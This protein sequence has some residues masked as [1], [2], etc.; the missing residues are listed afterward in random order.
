MSTNNAQLSSGK[1]DQLISSKAIGVIADID[2]SYLTDDDRIFLSQPEVCG[3]ILFSRNF[4]SLNQLQQLTAD[5]KSLRP[6]LLISADQEGGRVQRFRGGF[7]RIPAMMTFEKIWLTEGD[8][9][10]ASVSDM[11][12]LLALECR[13]AGVDLTYAPVLDIEQDCSQVIGDRAF[14]HTADGVT[15]LASAWCRGLARVGF[16]AIGKHFPGHGGVVADSHHELPIDPR[17]MVELQEDM[18]PFKCL[19][20]QG[21][22]AGIMPAHVIY[23]GVDKNH[24]AGFSDYWLQTVLRQE[25]Q[26]DG[27]I[28]SDDLSMTGAASAGDYSK[29]A[30]AAINA[31]ANALLACNDRHAAQVVIDTVKNHAFNKPRLDLSSWCQH[32]LTQDQTQTL[33]QRVIELSED[34]M[35]LGWL[36]AR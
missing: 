4:Q 27:V 1:S 10:L 9:C 15:Q 34:L 14:G 33:Q 30:L 16:K 31:G 5:I 13:L 23:S 19:I 18:A 20:E 21:Q 8:K 24:T 29:R 3:I 25:L 17:S 22:L 32:R 11:A 2:G 7:Y 6:D 35:N 26:F 36:T 28:F 12:E